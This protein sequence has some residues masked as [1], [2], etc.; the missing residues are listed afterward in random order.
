[1]DNST[2]ARYQYGYVLLTEERGTPHTE[3]VT[4][5]GEGAQHLK[6]CLD[7]QTRVGTLNMKICS[8]ANT[9]GGTPLM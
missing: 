1:M 5:R 3:I 8:D 7:V 2:G 9:M 4:D 6:L